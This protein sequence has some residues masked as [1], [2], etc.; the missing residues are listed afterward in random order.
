M[1]MNFLILAFLIIFMLHNLE[2][3]VAIEKWLSHTYPKKK[4]LIPTFFQK[5]IEKV[6]DMTAVQFSVVVFVV[7]VFVSPPGYN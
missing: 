4:E 5:E 3:I 1:D 6:K 2:E 7:S